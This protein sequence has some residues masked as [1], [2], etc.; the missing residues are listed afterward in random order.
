MI[1]FL[2]ISQPPER[3]ADA[4]WR[5]DE[6]LLIPGAAEVSGQGVIIVVAD[7]VELVIVASGTGDRQ[8]Q[9]RLRNHVDLVV[10]PPDL[11]LADV[12]RR[13]SALAQEIEPGPDDRLIEPLDG[14]PARAGSRSPA[15]CSTT[16]RS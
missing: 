10:D 13:M 7:R 3:D 15:S 4:S 14:V 11:L 5:V 1:A 6:R 9:E 16:N 2:D 12:H 8:A